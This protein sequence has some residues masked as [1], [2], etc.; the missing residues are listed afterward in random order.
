MVGQPQRDEEGI[1]DEAG[2]H[3]SGEDD[4][5]HKA[6]ETRKQREAADG[7]EFLQHQRRRGP[8]R[9]VPTCSPRRPNDIS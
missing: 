9:M 7:Q 5:P 4:V 3:H 1:G 2:A 8:V 6:G